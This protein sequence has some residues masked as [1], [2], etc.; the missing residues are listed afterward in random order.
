[1]KNKFLIHL[2]HFTILFVGWIAVMLIFILPGYSLI[3]IPLFLLS[4]L[5]ALPASWWWYGY[6]KQIFNK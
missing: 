2:I 6:L 1:M 4:L 5:I 3:M